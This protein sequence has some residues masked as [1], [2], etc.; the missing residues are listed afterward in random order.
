MSEVPK[1]QAGTARCNVGK[2]FAVKFSWFLRGK[3]ARSVEG[4][5]TALLT[6][7]T[8]AAVVVVFAKSCRCASLPTFSALA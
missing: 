7:V 2:S 8:T 3:A 5:T 4:G 6:F 1:G